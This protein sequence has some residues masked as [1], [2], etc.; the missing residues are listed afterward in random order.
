MDFGEVLHPQGRTSEDVYKMVLVPPAYFIF[1]PW[2]T[3]LHCAVLVSTRSS[4][5]FV[6]DLS[7]FNIQMP[8]IQDEKML[9]PIDERVQQSRR[10]L[11]SGALHLC[12][13]SGFIE[14]GGHNMPVACLGLCNAFRDAVP[15]RRLRV[16]EETPPA[17]LAMIFPGCPSAGLS[18]SLRMLPHRRVVT[19][20]LS[21]PSRSWTLFLPPGTDVCP[22]SRQEPHTST[23]TLPPSEEDVLG[24]ASWPEGVREIV[25]CGFNQPIQGGWWPATLERLVFSPEN[26]SSDIY[27]MGDSFNQTLVGV[28]WPVGLRELYLGFR[29]N[30]P[31]NEVQWPAGLRTLSMPGFDQPLAGMQWPAGLEALEFLFPRA[32]ADIEHGES[33]DGSYLFGGF[34]QSLAG[35]GVLPS[36]LRR[37]WLSP[38]FCQDL[39]DVSWPSQL[40]EIGIFGR[41]MADAVWPSTLER[42]YVVSPPDEALVGELP[43]G[44][45]VVFVE[46]KVPFDESEYYASDLDAYTLEEEFDLANGGTDEDSEHFENEYE[47]ASD[48]SL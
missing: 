16:N 46:E 36:G 11:R 6:H 38:D 35:E 44:C 29:F 2:T 24:A 22:P 3:V 8:I 30:Q 5:T 40:R 32:I 10:D 39:S 45:K 19:L 25:L 34:N 47:T 21:W 14:G 17:L 31:I 28:K 18:R 26:T 33:L 13:I 43:T 9:E 15:L 48:F 4:T 7:L 37:L 12:A 41:P 23:V 20:E 42:L 27:K 1:L